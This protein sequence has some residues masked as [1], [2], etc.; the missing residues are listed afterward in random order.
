MMAHLKTIACNKVENDLPLMQYRWMIKVTHPISSINVVTAVT[1]AL[2][3]S[4]LR[5]NSFALSLNV[6]QIPEG[7]C[8]VK[9]LSSS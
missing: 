2:I 5:F 1:S 9:N 6:S 4:F 7:G 3:R 8:K